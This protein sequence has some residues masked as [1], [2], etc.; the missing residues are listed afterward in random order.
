MYTTNAGQPAIGPMSTQVEAPTAFNG[1]SDINFF[2]AQMQSTGLP[3]KGVASSMAGN[4]LNA[5][6]PE[7][8]AVS[9]RVKR[10]MR[11]MMLNKQTKEAHAL[12]ES[13]AAANLDV[14][15]RVK[16]LGLLVKGVD[17]I[18]TMG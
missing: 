18:A 12:P 17:K 4:L 15:A 8:A 3:D 10:G 13:L 2:N 14:V 16:T 11:D 5:G 6:V 1:S 7:S 9:R